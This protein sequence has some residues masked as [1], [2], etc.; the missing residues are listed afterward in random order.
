[1]SKI[2]T[3]LFP[4]RTSIK[5]V[6]LNQIFLLLGISF[7]FSCENDMNEIN[8]I[9]AQEQ[10]ATEVAHGVDMIYSDSALVKVRV[11]ASTMI[12]HLDKIDP[13][14]EFTEGIK[15]V[16]FTPNQRVQSTLTAKKAIRYDK[17]NQIIVRDSVVW[18]SED[19]ERLETEELIWEEL[20]DRV[21]SNKF[22]KITQPED[23][24]YGYGF[25]ANQDFT[26]WTINA[27]KG[28][29]GVK[30]LDVGN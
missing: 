7:L 9:I 20:K 11:E 30:G 12:R 21:Y 17:K 22:V 10:L 14:Q 8:K 3:T 13:Y 6:R 27:L 23:V 18:Q 29:M 25:E 15:V 4:K 24:I 28:D 1:M 16:F 26:H 5:M 19:G 2:N